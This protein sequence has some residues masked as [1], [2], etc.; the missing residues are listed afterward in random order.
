[1]NYRWLFRFCSKERFSLILPFLILPASKVKIQPMIDIRVWAGNWEGRII[2]NWF[3][4]LS[5]HINFQSTFYMIGL[6]EVG[7]R[8]GRGWPILIIWDNQIFRIRTSLAE[9]TSMIPR[10]SFW[11]NKNM[12]SKLMTKYSS[13]DSG[14]IPMQLVGDKNPAH[15]YLPPYNLANVQTSTTQPWLERAYRFSYQKWG[16]TVPGCKSI[17]FLT[18]GVKKTR[19]TITLQTPPL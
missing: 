16:Q 2:K 8:G 3:L 9:W 12:W 1:M 7:G 13:D 18:N 11:H 10:G 19:D 14:S 5:L 6:W 17:V 15:P 4:L